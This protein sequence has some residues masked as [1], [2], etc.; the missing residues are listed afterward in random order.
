LRIVLDA[1]VL[2]RAHPRSRSVGRKLLNAVLEGS[3]TLLLSNEIIVE[4]TRC[5]VIHAYRNFML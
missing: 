4:T 1:T 2:V 3:H 5:F